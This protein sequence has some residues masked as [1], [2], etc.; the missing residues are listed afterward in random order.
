MKYNRTLAWSL[1]GHWTILTPH[2]ASLIHWAASDSSVL[3][4]VFF[5]RHGI[6][7]IGFRPKEGQIRQ[8]T[9]ASRDVA[10][11]AVCAGPLEITSHVWHVEASNLNCDNT[12]PTSIWL[13]IVH[14]FHFSRLFYGLSLTGRP[15]SLYNSY[16]AWYLRFSLISKLQQRS[17][18]KNWDKNIR[19]KVLYVTGASCPRINKC[20]FSLGL[21]PNDAFK[22]PSPRLDACL[23]Y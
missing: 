9:Q 22:R 2:G 6:S 3:N 20:V 5:R 10:F 13:T 19:T 8:K 15:I 23:I 12:L 17:V 11:F 1:L 16:Y 7:S 4:T 21:L 18:I 14:I